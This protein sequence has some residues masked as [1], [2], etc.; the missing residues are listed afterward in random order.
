MNQT[1][2]TKMREIVDNCLGHEPAYCS[3]ACPMHTDIKGYVN[4]IGEG[5]FDEAI[6]LIRE[7]LF[8]PATLG[9]ICAHPCEAACK[10]NDIGTA[11]SIAN[12]KRFVADNY[13]TA[14][15]WDLSRR[16][17]RPESIAIIGA[18]PAG[19]QAAFDLARE[20]FSVTVFDRLDR[21]GGMMRVGIPAYRLPRHIIDFEYSILEKLGVEFKLGVDIGNDIPF[22]K[23]R[24]DFDAT[25]IAIGA[26][27]GVIIPVPGHELPGVTDA[28][29]FLRTV[30][31]N[32]SFD[33]LGMVTTV[34]GG[35]NVAVDAARSARRLGAE[36]HLVMLESDM[37]SAPAHDWELIEAAE[38]GVHIVY[39]RSAI[40]IDGDERVNSISFQRCTRVFDDNGAF[41]PQYDER[42]VIEIKTD[43]VIFAVGQSTQ[44]QIAPD[45]K[46]GRGGRF[47]V[48][49]LTLQTKD[50]RV[51]VAG[52]ASG[53]SVIAVEAMAEG[54]K[55]AETLI[56]MF[57]GNNLRSGRDHRER[58]YES[59][60]K[61]E[62]PLDATKRARAE[63]KKLSPE[64]RVSNFEQYDMGLTEEQARIEAGG[65]LSCECLKCVKEC[66]MLSDF[67]ECPK[68]LFEDMLQAQDDVDPLIPYSCN[69]CKQC[70]ISCP[71][72]FDMQ[73]IFGGMRV[74]MVS[75]NRGKSP[76]KGHGVIDMHQ[77]LGFSKAFNTTVAAPEG[78]T[79][80]V[81]I[82]G[83]SLPSHNPQ[84]VGKIFSHLQDRLG[85]TGAILKCCGKPTKALGQA[86][87]FKERYAELQAEIDKLGADE[88]IV[89]CQSC[90]LTMSQ[91]SP[92]QTVKSLWEIMPEIG[93]PEGTV[94]K[95]GESPLTFAIHDSCSTRDKTEIHDGIRWILDELGYQTEEPPHTR[96]TTRCCGFGGMVVPANPEL[97][98]RVMSRR[99][100]EVQSD[101][102][103]T[104]CAACRESM[105]KGGKQSAHIL[106]L[107]FE[108][109]KTGSGDFVGTPNGPVGPW[110]NRYKAKQALNHA[111]KAHSR[112]H[113]RTKT[114]EL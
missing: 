57:D 20:G 31:I 8:L 32:E 43:S 77:A 13:D 34:I 75:N 22:E 29:E 89:A 7:K 26:H 9:R 14:D 108:P 100:A 4:L 61:T 56:R 70:T 107:V 76:M 24:S 85:N 23:L 15:A 82:P 42:N 68:E 81:F 69:M 74:E 51:L 62:V 88:I 35:G 45:L 46:S 63:T 16:A 40:A 30:S 47:A 93:M 112:Q 106:D 78:V 99:T 21:F 19:A 38:E 102:M 48:D 96:E 6:E 5:R 27:Q 79:K 55:A 41:N 18:G 44:S 11:M 87:Q 104:Y 111:G 71:Q 39:G 72:E 103:V 80:R 98:G 52:D 33:D 64:L 37:E 95:G 94:G 66:E 2:N 3:A 53:H 110:M 60:L 28:V 10:R 92:N 25:I 59:G 1:L 84:A 54:R 90:F 50:P 113:K 58:A 86:S 36:V 114:P 49:D 97:A 65:C 67:T 83:C 17:K 109:V 73:G 101:S 12:L 91:Y 105:V